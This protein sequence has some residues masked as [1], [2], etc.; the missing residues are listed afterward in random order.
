M[1]ET[2]TQTMRLVAESEPISPRLLNP[3]V[4]LDLETIC[5]KCLEKDAGRRYAS[6]Q[7]LADELG[8]FLRDEPILARP[9]RAPGKLLR[10]CR[11]KP[12]LALSLGAAAMLF[13]VIVIG[14]PIAI[15]RIDRGRKMAEAA[16]RRTQTQLY[17]ALLEQARAT[18]R[19]AELGQRVNALDALRRAAAISNTVELRRE[20]LAA[21]SLPD[22]R[23]ERQLPLPTNATEAA[24]DPAFERL[25]I[26][27]GTGPVEIRAVADNRL[28]ALLPASTNLLAYQTFW[29]PDGKFLS[30]K[31]DWDAGG[32]RAE[33]EVWDVA[34]ARLVVVLPGCSWGAIS[35]HPKRPWIMAAQSGA[36][37][38]WDLESGRELKRFPF[39]SDPI[40]LVRYSPDGESFAARQA[41][42]GRSAVTVRSATSGE[43]MLT[44][45]LTEW[46]AMLAWHP[47]RQWLA[48]ADHDGKIQL[49]DPQTGETHLLGR[50]KAQAVTLAFS[51]DGNYL[52]SGGWEREMICWD[53]GA[54]QR[55]FSIGLDSY[56]FQFSTDGRQCST[57][58]R[59]RSTAN[60]SIGF[61][62]DLKLHA[63]EP[64]VAHREFREEL[65]AQLRSAA[66]SPDGRW[67]AASANKRCGLWDLS[68]NEPG[69][70]DSDAYNTQLCFTRD[71]Q[72]LFAS[73]TEEGNNECFRWQFLPAMNHASPPQLTRLP[74]S[75]P[76]GFTSLAVH[77]NTIVFT[78][79]KGSQL[80]ALGDLEDDSRYHWA[81]TSQGYN[82]IS[83][84]GK[85]LAIRRAYGDALY[86]HRLPGLEEV[87]KLKDEAII[88]DFQFSPL[89]DEMVTF[90]ASRHV[91][92]FW[93]VGTWEKIR[94]VTNVIRVLYT[95]DPRLLWLARDWRT[96]GLYDAQTLEPLLPLPVGTHPLALGPDG[97][98]LA[99]SMELRRLLV[100]DLGEVRRRLRET[101]LDWGKE[102]AAVSKP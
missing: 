84:D 97:R 45:D 72:A 59:S 27:K 61:Y 6:A 60:A 21:L 52:M 47:K 88:G 16:E 51:P 62:H 82:G 2:L 17:T 78:G 7:E 96:A 40:H 13:L 87:A 98:H 46:I 49:L 9:L 5:L 43:V 50:H 33:L 36:V 57:V 86:I 71:G 73:R 14:S 10:W 15:V 91:A 77:S 66:F 19:S 79:E 70:L 34:A 18:V 4:P 64:A 75:K 35:F 38:I 29:G 76:D 24:L 74:L 55:A 54:R 100:W 39:S 22:L 41:L 92:T 12:A 101:G 83:P 23:F 53:I 69:A 20:A 95:P 85:W 1:A 94:S 44:R 30:V 65:G 63:F 48:L 37:A 3:G 68:R 99:V 93:R 102:D 67:L 8:R 42:S 56:H 25:A 89:S 28:I 58:V 26:C 81:Q 31:R 11:R 80:S 90:S 32:R